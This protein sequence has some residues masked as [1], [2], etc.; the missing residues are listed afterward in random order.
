[1]FKVKKGGPYHLYRG[2]YERCPL[3]LLRRPGSKGS[4]TRNGL[5]RMFV[6]NGSSVNVIFL[7]TYEQ[8]NIDVLLEP[9]TKPLYSFTVD[10]VTPK[11]IVHHAV[12]MGE[13]PLAAHTF[14][15]FLPEARKYYRNALRKAE[16]NEIIMTFIDVKMVEASEESPGDIIMEDDTSP[17]DI[18]PRVTRV[19]SHTSLVEELES[20]FVDP[21]DPTRKL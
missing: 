5:G 13:E 18:D 8:I 6:D 12:T 20:F 2:R 19:D 21:S 14:M 3:L 4:C 10:F 16:K 7:S 17:E 9:S 15:E 1:M 11:G